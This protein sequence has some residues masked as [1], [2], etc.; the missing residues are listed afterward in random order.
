MGEHF[1]AKIMVTSGD[2]KRLCSVYVGPYKRLS[3]VELY[4]DQNDG[5]WKPV[6]ADEP[7][8]DANGPI[9]H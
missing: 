2:R 7:S 6:K 5:E 4:F 9:K 1:P 3:A 8:E